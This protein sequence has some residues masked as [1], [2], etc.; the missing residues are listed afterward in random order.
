MTWVSP[1]MLMKISFITLSFV[2]LA[3]LFQV[4]LRAHSTGRR[5][6]V[7]LIFWCVL[8]GALSYFGLITNTEEFPPRVGLLLF[9]NMAVA[10]WLWFST[11]VQQW[12]K[13][14]SLQTLTWLQVFRVGVEFQLMAMSGLYLLPKMMT[15]EGRNFDILTGL[16]AP[17]V[18]YLFHKKILSKRALL[19]WNFTGLALLINVVTHGILTLPSIQLINTEIP[20]LA[21]GYFPYVWLPGLFVLSALGLHVLSLSKLLEAK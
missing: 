11:Q 20:N 8:I 18:A 3:V 6:F 13:S 12:L 21:L 1:Y 2:W 9:F 15:F 14:V 19:V 4:L 16:S 10:S 5:I 7:G 17:L